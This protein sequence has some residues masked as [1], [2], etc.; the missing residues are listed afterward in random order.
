M[1][2][3][4]AAHSKSLVQWVAVFFE[5]LPVL[6][7]SGPERLNT[8]SASSS[9]PRIVSWRYLRALERAAHS[10]LAFLSDDK[11]L[12]VA[13][14]NLDILIV[15]C[16]SEPIVFSTIAHCLRPDR[17]RGGVILTQSF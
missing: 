14:I 4:T 11:R 9:E 12:D 15:P 17:L 2:L 5:M 1:C 16:L 10:I 13:S 6:G 7:E 3:S 8:I